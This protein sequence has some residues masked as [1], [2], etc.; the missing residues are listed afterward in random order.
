MT[1]PALSI[2]EKEMPQYGMNASELVYPGEG[3]PFA[4]GSAGKGF[5]GSPD[6]A[7][8][9]VHPATPRTEVPRN[10]VHPGAAATAAILQALTGCATACE[11]CISSCQSMKESHHVA[12]CMA[13]AKACSD[14]CILLHSYVSTMDR[15]S[16]V[17][18]ALDLSPVCARVCEAC[19]LECSKHPNMEACVACE[20]A[21][22][23][24][25]TSC[26]AFAR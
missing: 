26:R 19:A 21:C 17:L 24:C 8:T 10:K 9:S 2:T 11:R 15:D 23:T 13:T 20:M 22:R 4:K 3:S 16:I 14:I 6:H 7:G 5:T 1:G 18:M 25:A 12:D